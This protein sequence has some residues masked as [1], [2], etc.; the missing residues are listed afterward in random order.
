[1]CF[2]HAGKEMGCPRPHSSVA[3]QRLPPGRPC[4][5]VTLLLL[6]SASRGLHFIHMSTSNSG[7]GHGN[8]LQYSC[9]GNPRQCCRKEDPFQGPKPGSCLILGNEL[10]EETHL[11]TKPE[12][13]L[14]KGTQVES[15]RV[16]E[17]RRI[18]LSQGLQSWVLW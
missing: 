8:P 17:P 7:E 10:S 6:W 5:C 14:G 4:P 3:G 12:I 13:L 1:M 16:R 2:P 9:L 15:R 11:L 18:A